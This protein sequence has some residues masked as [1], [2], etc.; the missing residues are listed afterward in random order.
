[1]L[2][3]AALTLGALVALAMLVSVVTCNGCTLGFALI[4]AAMY[5]R[6]PR[7]ALCALAT[8]GPWFTAGRL[9][10]GARRVMVVL[11][12]WLGFLVGLWTLFPLDL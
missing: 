1:M 7:A 5:V 8:L 2:K 3:Y 4:L 10:P 6:Y 12:A 11:V 9:T